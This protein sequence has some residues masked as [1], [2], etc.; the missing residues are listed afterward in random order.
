MPDLTQMS[1]E[2]D[3]SRGLFKLLH[4]AAR[5]HPI[6][7]MTPEGGTGDRARAEQEV[8]AAM[9]E[10]LRGGKWDA[11]SV[12]LQVLL[13]RCNHLSQVFTGNPSSEQQW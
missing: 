13:G 4:C 2:R 8:V 9:L 3:V 10:M 7:T 6:Q 11:V 12:F 1:L 5:E